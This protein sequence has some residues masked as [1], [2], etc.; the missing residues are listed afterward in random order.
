MN[1]G[2]GDAFDLG[3]KLA[4]VIK[5]HGGDGLLRSYDLERKPVA[6]RNVERS[7]IHFQVHSQLQEMIG[8]VDPRRLDSE[9]DE[10]RT[11]RQKLH[12][13]YQM[14]D[15]ENKDLGIEMGYRYSSPLI[16][17]SESD[18]D[19]PP[20]VPR[21]YT[22]TTWPGGRPP[23]LFLSDG[24]AI[25]D[26]FG[27]NWTLLVFIVGDVGQHH[28]VNA[29]TD[30]SLP[31]VLVELSNEEYARKLYERDLVLI[32]PDQHVAWRS[33]KIDSIEGAHEL[34]R[35]VTGRAE[36]TQLPLST[37]VSEPLEQL[38]PAVDMAS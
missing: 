11:L 38:T 14:N 12:E 21:R 15:G 19:E 13:Y 5:G 6:L 35:I 4:S 8:G 28:L 23:H 22:P 2:I 27:K 1:M 16:M 20:F 18:D 9:T 3:W 30:S 33:N 37:E 34:L 29:A 36:W 10:G 32:R 26:K 17:V 25:F 24:T 31:L 7:G